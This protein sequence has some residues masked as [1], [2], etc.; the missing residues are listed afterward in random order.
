MENYSG[1]PTTGHAPLILL[2]GLDQPT[3]GS[4]SLGAGPWRLDDLG[5][6]ILKTL[7]SPI[8]LDPRFTNRAHQSGE[9]LGSKEEDHDATDDQPLISTEHQVL[10]EMQAK[11][12]A[13]GILV[14]VVSIVFHN[15]QVMLQG[16]SPQ[17]RLDPQSVAGSMPLIL[18]VI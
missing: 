15:G 6:M 13:Q 5:V 4:G 17:H 7:S 11:A 1:G 3:T 14:R 12:H 2:G 10:L 8:E 18:N 9:T 16:Q